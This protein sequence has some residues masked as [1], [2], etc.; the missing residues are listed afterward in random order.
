MTASYNHYT[1]TKNFDTEYLKALQ[2]RRIP[3][4]Y[5]FIGQ[6]NAK[7]WIDTCLKSDYEYYSK[8]YKFLDSIK[9]D[10]SK[11]ISG[12]VN[13]IA[14][15]SPN[16]TKDKL[17]IEEFQKTK[18]VTYSLVDSSKELASYII[19]DFANINIPKEVFISDI[20]Q[21]LDLISTQL[22][23]NYHSK[24]LF[25]ILTNTFGTYSQ[26]IISKPIR[27]AMKRDD[28][29]L[30]E[31][32]IT[33]DEPSPKYIQN[34]LNS[35]NNTFYNSHVMQVFSKCDITTDDGYMEVHYGEEKFFPDIN[36]VS[37]YFKFTR[38][39]IVKF[40]GEDI[41]FSKGERILAAYSN[42]YKLEVLRKVIN[43]HGFS[44]KKEFIDK[45]NGYSEIL[46]QLN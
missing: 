11:C 45:E 42:K 44:I 12:D 26:E 18:Q 8:P 15:G 41:Y 29:L 40:M 22:R 10:I 33:P 34:V 5:K 17:L 38:S 46:C 16:L 43:T 25:T 1:T 39:R 30:I 13:L 37:H 14:L 24:N 7:A 2:I 36:V 20:T 27:D 23:D 21:N 28:Y 9:S 4:K 31:V 3:P 6:K 32:H 35:Y 19:E